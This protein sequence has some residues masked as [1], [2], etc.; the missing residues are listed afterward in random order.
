MAFSAASLRLEGLAVVAQVDALVALELVGH[1][2]DDALV[3]VVAAEEGVAVGGLDLEDAVAHVE[4]G[5]VEGAAAQVVDGDGLILL[6]VQTIG[7]RRSG[8][9]VDDAQDF[10]AGD[11]AGVLGG[12][13]LRVVEVGRHSDDG[14]GDGLAEVSFGIGLDLGQDHGADPGEEYSLPPMWTRTS[15]L[16][17][18]LTL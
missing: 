17:A 15:P 10:Q 7:Q 18:A 6:L 11:A 9:L 12:L 8:R 4:H 3:E 13:A 1:P 16:G 14:L 2:V 5:D